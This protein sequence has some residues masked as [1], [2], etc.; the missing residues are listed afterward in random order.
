MS[1][2]IPE[3]A[4]N[5]YI[6]LKQLIKDI[7]KCEILQVKIISLAGVPR[8]TLSRII[9]E[10]IS[11]YTHV[12]DGDIKKIIKVAEYKEKSLNEAILK[13]KLKLGIK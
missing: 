8:H 12:S 10:P 9:K 4:N 3:D 2:R 11:S 1:G 6:I 5:N 7:K 13:A